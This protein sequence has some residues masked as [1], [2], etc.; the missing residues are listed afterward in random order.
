MT[1]G[2]GLRLGRYFAAAIAGALISRLLFWPEI[3][4]RIEIL[5]TVRTDTVYQTYRDTIRIERERVREVYMRD[6]VIK[7]VRLPINR[8]SG[9]EPTIFGD[10]S[11]T[12]LVAGHF[13]KMELNTNFKVPELK[14]TI[15]RETIKTRVIKPRG[16]Y[17]GGSVSDQ[18]DFSAEAAYLDNNWLFNYRYK[19]GTKSHSIGVKMKVW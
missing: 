10:V 6:T 1:Y 9:L 7:T 15:N 16:L 17:V 3:T 2:A 11:Y 13:L 12:G 14:T 5:E 18:I 8:F 19:I 4:E